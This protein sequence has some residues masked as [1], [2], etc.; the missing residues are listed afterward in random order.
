MLLV[1]GGVV[2]GWRSEGSWRLR[3]GT[4]VMA[5]GYVEEISVQC[6]HTHNDFFH[7]IQCGLCR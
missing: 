6:A 3:A 1:G 2:D 4:V 7:A 5:R